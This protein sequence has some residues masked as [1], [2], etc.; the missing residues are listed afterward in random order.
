MNEERDV[1]RG[2]RLEEAASSVPPDGAAER[3][4]DR[5]AAALAAGAAPRA[6]VLAPPGRVLWPWVVVGIGLLA[7]ALMAWVVWPE[8]EPE[9]ERVVIAA[10]VVEVMAEAPVVVPLPVR[11]PAPA[12]VAAPVEERAAPRVKREVLKPAVLEDSFAAELRR[13]AAAQAAL[14]DGDTGAALRV[15]KEHAVLFPAGQ[16]AQDREALRAVALCTAGRAQ[17]KQLAAKFLAAH[18]GSIHADRV[19]DACGA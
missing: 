1:L 11:A 6:V 3:G 19:R 7:A 9:P 4:W 8:S 13:I 15:L 2:W 5:L 18:P 16:F 12:G 14:R 17:G 10:P